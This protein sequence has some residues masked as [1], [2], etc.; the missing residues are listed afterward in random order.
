MCTKALFF[1]LSSGT[2]SRA[3]EASQGALPQ[4]C[5]RRTVLDP[6]THWSEETGNHRCIAQAD[7]A[8]TQC[9]QGSV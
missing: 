9:G 1:S 5:I 7:Q 4:A 2:H 3:G 8:V 6:C